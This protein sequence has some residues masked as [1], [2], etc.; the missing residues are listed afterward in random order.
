[1]TLNSVKALHIDLMVLTVARGPR[2]YGRWNARI[3]MRWME[4]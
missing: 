3:G 1:M 2:Q 4:L